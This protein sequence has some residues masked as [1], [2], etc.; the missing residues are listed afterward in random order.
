MINAKGRS[1][2]TLIII[3]ACI[4]LLLRFSSVQVIKWSIDQN[5][6]TAQESLKLISTALELYAKDHMGAYPQSLNALTQSEPSYI[7]KE[8]VAETQK[9]KG[10]VFTC[11]RLEPASY[12]C[13]AS[14]DRCGLTGKKI[15]TVTTGGSM[16][17]EECS[18]D[19]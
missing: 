15:F 8:Y 12:S 6:A 4:A 5:E 17:T 18:K 11:S 3:I 13:S 16:L 1:F 14:P 7:S 10:Y 2:L 9:R 19:E